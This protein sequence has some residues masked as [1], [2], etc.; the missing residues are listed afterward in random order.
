VLGYLDD[1]ILVPA[2]IALVLR[3][4]PAEVMADCR[5]QARM[6]AERPISRIGAAVMIAI[7]LT[8]AAWVFLLVRDLF[9]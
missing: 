7:W 5:E 1:L 8:A 6:G 4:V 9:G 2:G 3:L